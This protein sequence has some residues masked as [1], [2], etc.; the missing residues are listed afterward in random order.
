MQT[1]DVLAE[2]IQGH[3]RFEEVTELLRRGVEDGVSPGMGVVVSRNGTVLY[4]HS[5]GHKTFRNSKTPDPAAMTLE[6][7]FDLAG[8]TM[9]MVTTTLIMKL[10]E[11]QRLRLDDRVCR[12]LQGFGVLGKSPITVRHLLNHTSGMPAWHPFYEELL[13]AQCGDRRG[14]LTSRG[15]R[16]Y[17]LTCIN[18]MSLKYEVGARQVF[19]DINFILLGFLVELLTGVSL[20]KAA[21]RYVFQTLGLKSTSYVDLSLMKRRGIHPITDVIAPTEDCPWR[22]RVLCGEVHD[23]NA[24]AMGGISGHSG[25][26]S[27]AYDVHTFGCELLR[28]YYG[29]STLIR[30]DVV[31]S[32]WE[33]SRSGGKGS[34]GTGSNGASERG[35]GWRLG[36]DSPSQENGLHDAGLGPDA[37][38]CNGFTGC[39]LWIEPHDRIVA[40]VVSNRVHPTRSNKKI[41]AFRPELHRT[42]FEAARRF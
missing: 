11:S 2:K 28:A 25:L 22:K 40:I 15:A 27:T 20:E 32:F 17:V 35:V 1:A 36:W 33:P 10:V 7:V 30:S 13:R 18:R 14:I 26:F 23:D 6:T 31:R 24:W 3:S 4:A 42:I 37:V 39:S 12:Y 8:L 9:V 29:A 34:S 38:G 41:L 5:H 16:D 21:F 19:S